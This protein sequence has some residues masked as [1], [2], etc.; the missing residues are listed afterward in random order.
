MLLNK[1][2]KHILPI[3]LCIAVLMYFVFPP[4]TVKADAIILT[5]AITEVIIAVLISVGIEPDN[6]DDWA[7]LVDYVWN[8]MAYDMQVRFAEMADSVQVNTV[9]QPIVNIAASSWDLISTMLNSLFMDSE[10]QFITNIIPSTI[11]NFSLYNVSTYDIEYYTFSAGQSIELLLGSTSIEVEHL[12]TGIKSYIHFSDY[13]I[14]S[15]HLHT[16]SFGTS[17][18][19]VSYIGIANVT[20]MNDGFLNCNITFFDQYGNNLYSTFLG[21]WGNNIK[22]YISSEN[23]T[24]SRVIESNNLIYASGIVIGEADNVNT[25]LSDCIFQDNAISYDVLTD[26]YPGVGLYSPG[27]VT[28][29]GP[30]VVLKVPVA[31]TLAELWDM[32]QSWAAANVIVTSYAD[33]VVTTTTANTDLNNMRVPAMIYDKLPFS[34]PFDIY[35]FTT[36]LEADAVAPVF[37]FPFVIE[38]FDIDYDIVLDFSFLDS[39]A[40]IL[41][42]FVLATWVFS[43]AMATRYVVRG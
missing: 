3:M 11:P 33:T 30:D 23:F 20:Y 16:S 22:A 34:I 35:R 26:Y 19:N 41:R 25:W 13:T 4:V 37:T 9:N 21:E 42:F 38:R 7:R 27:T 32:I 39:V 31:G 8:N 12:S 17:N 36:I 5:I 18:T 2:K 14:T 43:L 6:G 24:Y 40:E 1:L 29:D 15:E 28:T 10:N